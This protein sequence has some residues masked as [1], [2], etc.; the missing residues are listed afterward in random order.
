MSKFKIT[1]SFIKTL[2]KVREECGGADCDDCRFSIGGEYNCC[3]NGIPWHW[4]DLEEL[5]KQESE[6]KQ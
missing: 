5:L 1:K 2:I 3:F 6:E 4:D